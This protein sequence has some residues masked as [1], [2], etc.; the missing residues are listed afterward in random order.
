MLRP[1]MQEL[2]SDATNG[3]FDVVMAEALDRLSRDQED[4]AGLYKRLSFSGVRIVTVA[5][6]DISEMHIG[7]K[8]TMNA[9]FLKDL[10]LKTHRGMRGRVEAGKSGG[11]NAYG[12][13]VIRSFNADGSPIAG[14]RD[15]EPAEAATVRRI[16]RDFANGQSP[17]AIAHALNKENILGPRDEGWGQST[18]NGN[19]ERGTGILNNELY[20]GRLVWNRLR[21]VKDP[22]TGKRVSRPNPPESFVIN[23]VPELRIVDDELWQAVKTRQKLARKMAFSSGTAALS[24]DDAAHSKPKAGFWSNHRPRHLLSGLMRCGTCGGAYS[25]VNT[26]LFGCAAA[27]NK[28]TCDNRLNIRVAAVDDIVLTGLKQRLMNPEIFKEFA[29][30]FIAERNTILAQQNAQFDTAKTELS[31]VK[32]RQKTLLQA[33]TDGVPARTVKDEMIALEAREDELNALLTDRPAREPALHP[34]LAEVYRER[35]AALHMAL[36]NSHTKDEAFTIIRT[37]IDEVRLVP[38]DGQLRIEIRGALAGI[39]A[40]AAN[41]KNHLRR[42]ADGSVSVLEQQIKLVAGA[43]FELTSYRDKRLKRATK[44]PLSFSMWAKN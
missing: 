41:D 35:V 37:L 28:G 14:E 8:G 18:I 12:Y 33:L 20:I 5:D 32:S 34:N 10:A 36:T 6:G 38:E 30:A 31:R 22:S 19:A 43:R 44:T 42:G 2:S 16:F 24:M 4:I 21:Y 3:R 39:L 26:R 9:L 1:G 23:E 11:G 40:L 15:I 25:K 13:K 29:S 7:L 17:R 27:R